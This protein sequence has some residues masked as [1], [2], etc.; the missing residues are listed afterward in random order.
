[1]ILV[2]YCL[3]EIFGTSQPTVKEDKIILAKSTTLTG[4]IAAFR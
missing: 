4:S 1:V 3:V 2:F